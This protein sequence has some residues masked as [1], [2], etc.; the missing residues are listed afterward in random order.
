LQWSEL[1]SDLQLLIDSIV[2]GG[3]GAIVSVMQRMTA[4]NLTLQ[5]HAGRFAL[6]RV[7]VFRPLIGA[8]FATVVFLILR[9]GL[10]T[11]PATPPPDER[12]R[13]LY[14]YAALAFFAGFSE[15]WAQDMFDAGGARLA[16]NSGAG[17]SIGDDAP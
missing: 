15:R 16:H 13:L 4:G 7:G 3:L 10:V 2:V 6:M 9:A 14:F 8:I 17:P 11:I 1:G 12:A 5:Y